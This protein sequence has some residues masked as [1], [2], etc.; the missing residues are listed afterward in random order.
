MTQFSNDLVQ[1]FPAQAAILTALK[2]SNA[3][4]H[5]LCEQYQTLN[6]VVHKIEAGLEAA[7]DERLEDMKKQ[8]L[9][10]LDAIAQHL[11]TAS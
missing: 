5:D 9:S 2:A 11:A 1:E 3:A 8:R 7:A 4:F 10:L 6:K